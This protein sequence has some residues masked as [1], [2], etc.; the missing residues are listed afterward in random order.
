MAKHTTRLS[1]FQIPRIEG[2]R[3]QD[4][5][6]KADPNASE[7]AVSAE[8]LPQPV[9][10]PRQL[11]EALPQQHTSEHA[12]VLNRIAPRP[13]AEPRQAMTVR[14]PVSMHE[15]IRMLM[16]T[17]RRSQQDIVEEALDAFLIANL[18]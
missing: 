1:D 9:S 16:F 14:L 7:V 2:I 3:A 11:A 18:T 4:K 8:P 10:P 13:L 15:R 5:A 12:V 17:S 6:L